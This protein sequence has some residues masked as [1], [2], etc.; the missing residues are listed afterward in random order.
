MC[1]PGKRNIPSNK[2]LRMVDTFEDESD[3]LQINSGR[4]CCKFKLYLLNNMNP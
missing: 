1:K 3:M 2:S 4:V